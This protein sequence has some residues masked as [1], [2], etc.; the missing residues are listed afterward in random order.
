M[1]VPK[2]F[3]EDKEQAAHVEEMLDSIF[4][5]GPRT[6]GAILDAFSSNPE[7]NNYPL[8]QITVPTLIIHT[9]DDPLASFEAANAAAERI[10]GAELVALD[11]GGHLGLGQTEPVRDAIAEFIS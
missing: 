3:P 7:I 6:E 8:E 5:L 9:K 11:S 10:P 1:G 4:P 2:G